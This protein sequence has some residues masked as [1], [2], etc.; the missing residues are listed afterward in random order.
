MRVVRSMTLRSVRSPISRACEGL[1]SGVA[2]QELD[3]LGERPHEHVAQLALA[4]EGARV[5]A[6][7]ALG[8]EVDEVEAVGAAQLAQLLLA[9]GELGA[10]A[11][12]DHEGHGAGAP[13]LGAGARGGGD[14][15]GLEVA[16][17]GEEVGGHVRREADGEVRGR[18]VVVAAEHAERDPREAADHEDVS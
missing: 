14:E 1:R 6:G 11:L 9:G 5:G 4:E 15:A 13:G 17:E 3:V 7:A 2:D 12:V 18:L 8:G 10:L 16:D